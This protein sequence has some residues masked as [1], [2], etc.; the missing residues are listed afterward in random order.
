M[1]EFMVKGYSAKEFLNICCGTWIRDPPTPPPPPQPKKGIKQRIWIF[2][3][4]CDTSG[5]IVAVNYLYIMLVPFSDLKS[6]T[7]PVGVGNPRY[8]NSHLYIDLVIYRT[9]S[10]L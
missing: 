8:H 5:D 10:F 9:L 1:D 6:S 4:F 7:F 3:Y 2:S